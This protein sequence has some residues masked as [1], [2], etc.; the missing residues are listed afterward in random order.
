MNTY[1]YD[2]VW[3][4]K[5]LSYNGKAITYDAAGHPLNY[6]GRTMTW[7]VN[8]R[9][10]SISDASAGGNGG[11]IAYT[12]LSDGSRRSKTVNGVT[13]TYHYNNGLLLSQST[14]DETLYFYY[15]STGNVTSMGYKKGSADEAGYFFTRNAQGDIIG[16]YRSSDSKLI[17]TYDYDL[18]GKLVSVTE[19]TAGIDTD[20]ILI[21]NPFRYRGYYYDEETGFYYLNARYYDPT[22]R[23]FISADTIIPL[24]GSSM[25]AYNLFAYCW[26]NPVNMS[27][28]SGNI[29]FFVVTA[30][31]GATAEAAN[32]VAD[33]GK[34]VSSIRNRKGGTGRTQA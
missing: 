19:A 12:Y 9:L 18:W 32:K 23:R 13:T 6:M 20:G 33:A 29:P 30:L 21:K 5:L 26:N 22:I 16:V 28:E 31:A 15:D 8:D 27:D 34:K 4:D 25:L 7:D 10:T 2:S 14:G 1:V 24:T 11:N 17:G 3:K